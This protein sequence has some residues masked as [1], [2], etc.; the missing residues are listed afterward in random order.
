MKVDQELY[1]QIL[2]NF[3][4]L[5]SCCKHLAKSRALTLHRLN[6]LYCLATVSLLCLPIFSE[7][8]SQSTQCRTAV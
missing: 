6:V 5:M 7:Q 1:T 4:W 3:E 8:L 2:L